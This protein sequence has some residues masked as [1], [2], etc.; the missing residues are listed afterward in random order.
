[1]TDKIFE[2]TINENIEVVIDSRFKI[3][4]FIEF[5]R[6]SFNRLEIKDNEYKIFLIKKI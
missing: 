2:I 3:K 6:L 4:G 1:M 5:I